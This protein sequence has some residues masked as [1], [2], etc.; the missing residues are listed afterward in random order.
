M[1]C[2]LT[3]RWVEVL[4]DYMVNLFWEES[5]P[6]FQNRR[7]YLTRYMSAKGVEDREEGKKGGGLGREE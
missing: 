4:D 6:L 1:R 2:C 7:K 5:D 3:F